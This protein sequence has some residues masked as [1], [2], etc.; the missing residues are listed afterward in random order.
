[1]R[2]MTTVIAD[3]NRTDHGSNLNVASTKPVQA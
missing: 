2:A 1:L 3:L